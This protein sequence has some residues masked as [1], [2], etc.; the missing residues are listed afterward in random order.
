MKKDRRKY[1]SDG[2]QEIWLNDLRETKI[3]EV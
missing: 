3:P 2:R 1:R